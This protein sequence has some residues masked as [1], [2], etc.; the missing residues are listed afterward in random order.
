MLGECLNKRPNARKVE[1]FLAKQLQA[2]INELQVDQK[3]SGK[4]LASNA[5]LRKFQET[6]DTDAVENCAHTVFPVGNLIACL[7]S[8]N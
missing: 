7:I 5:M 1:Q 3:I 2:K 8:A 4:F 6:A